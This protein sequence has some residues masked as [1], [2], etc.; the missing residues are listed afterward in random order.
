MKF[1]TVLATTA[2]VLGA[3][4]STI[5]GSCHLPDQFCG[6]TKRE[7]MPISEAEAEA[8]VGGCHLP[9]QSCGKAKR[10]A[11]AIAKVITKAY[12]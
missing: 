8:T 5:P 10:A 7:A 11:E 1:T 4:A 9:G 6:K 12:A 3:T 2:L